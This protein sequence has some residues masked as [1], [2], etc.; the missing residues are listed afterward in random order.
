MSF[1]PTD[2]QQ[3][4]IK[5]F[6]TGENMTIEAVAGSGK[7]ST[8]KLMAEAAPQKRGLYIAFNKSVQLDAEASFP[9]NVTCKTVH[10][11]AY[12]KIIG[13]SAGKRQRLNGKRQYASDIVRILNITGELTL[14]AERSV[15]SNEIAR[16]ARETVGRFCQSADTE[17]KADHVPV[18]DWAQGSDHKALVSRVLPF[19]RKF[20]E[21]VIKEVSPLKYEHDFY[22]KE[23]QLSKPKLGFYD[24]ILLDEAQDTNPVVVDVLLNQTN[25]VVTVGDRYQNIYAWRGSVNAMSAFNSKHHIYLTQSFRFGEAVA[26][27]ANKWLRLLDSE[28]SVIGFDKVDSVVEPVADPR[29][30][31]CRTNA[32]AIS[33]VMAEISKGRKPALVGGA[34]EIL[35]FAQAAEALMKG[36]KTNHKDLSAFSTWEDVVQYVKT[37]ASGK[38]LSVNV[39]LVESYGTAAIMQAC[40]ST[41]DESKA[42]VVISTSHKSKGREWDSVKIGNDFRAPKEKGDVPPASEMMLLYVSCTRAKLALDCTSLEWVNELV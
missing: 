23:W 32:G 39:N 13:K 31:L 30:I 5:A 27:E 19:A 24:F 15:S 40:N 16:I 28:V 33:Q 34:Q 35:Y 38:D 4:A 37:D 2:E 18:Q 9:S 41:V 36:T 8:L 10:S 17:I 22:V 29:A 25:Q 1:T 14:D 12:G 3:D 42:D 6:V 26:A 7:T 21:M 20:W 11:L